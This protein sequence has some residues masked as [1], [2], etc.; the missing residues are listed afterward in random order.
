[1]NV[2]ILMIL[3]AGT[4]TDKQYE[5][6]NYEECASEADRIMKHRPDERTYPIAFCVMKKD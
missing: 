2:W 1:M 5:F 6:D 4:F 3:F